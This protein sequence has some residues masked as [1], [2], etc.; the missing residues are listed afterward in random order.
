M[1]GME[2]DKRIIFYIFAIAAVILYGTLGS[3]FLGQNNN[4]NV[5]INSWVDAIYFT[6]VTISTV[7]YGDITP[8]TDIGR[9][10]VVILI[11]SGLSIFLSAITVLS[12]EFLSARV[13]KL[14]SGMGSVNKKK[15]NKHIVLIGYDSA[16]ELISN[17]LK[18]Q[19]R[20]FIIITADKS[21]AEM[22]RRKGYPAFL[23]DYTS[24]A[25]LEKFNLS[26]ATDIVIDLKD[27]SKAVYVVLVVKKLAKNTKISVITHTSDAEAHLKDLDIDNIINPVT[28]AADILT[29]DLDR[30]QDTS[31]TLTDK[32]E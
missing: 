13:E 14:Y 29:K 30:D 9:I 23:E 16:N 19:H 27:S 7:G 17:K 18:A 32:S 8:V 20:N 6:V 1:V 10:F 31:D 15:M 3:Y 5:K 2:I 4:F 28:I 12:G 25:D 24:K 22:L 26:K 21:T 11:I